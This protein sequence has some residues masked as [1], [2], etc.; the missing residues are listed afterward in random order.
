[1]RI[2]RPRA[3]ALT[4]ISVAGAERDFRVVSSARHATS[5]MFTFF[6]TWVREGRYHPFIR[7]PRTCKKVRS[8][9]SP[10]GREQGRKEVN[11]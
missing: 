4:A 10:L 3:E 6:L 8:Q 5:Y 11:R 2:V 7:M 9:T 1:M